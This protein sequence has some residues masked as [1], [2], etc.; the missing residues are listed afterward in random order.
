MEP[1]S[2][3]HN[4]PELDAL[5]RARRPVPDSAFVRA[6]EERLLPRRSRRSWLPQVPAV[7]VGAALATGL[8]ALVL[9]LSLIGVGPLGH[10]DPSVQAQDHC[11][12]VA[13]MKT[14]RV[15]A[16]V[17]NRHGRATVVY[18]K[19]RVRRYVRRCHR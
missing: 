6:T 19:Q 10:G 12:T 16:I 17:R 4:E 9:A 13:V 2:P 15:P 18:S 8:A 14:E 7:R 5:L 1:R 11:R 3:E